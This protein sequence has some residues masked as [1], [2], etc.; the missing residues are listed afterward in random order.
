[1]KPI[2]VILFFSIFIDTFA[3]DLHIETASTNVSY[4]YFSLPNESE[5]N[6]VDL[7]KKDSNISYRLFYEKNYGRW[8]WT[9]LYAPLSIND[10]FTSEKGF[11]FNN[12]NFTAG[13]MTSVK[14]VFNSYRLGYR[15]NYYYGGSR[16]YYGALI[17]IRDAEICITQNTSK[18]CYDNIGPVPLLNVGVELNFKNIY[19]ASN[20]DGLWSSRGSAYDANLE[21]GLNLRL[22]KLAT[23]IRV[24]GGGADNETLVNFAQFQSAYLKLIF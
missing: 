10:T 8:S 1:M 24:L 4:N 19:L 7:P 20:I 13:Q 15:R 17:K 6:R 23:G 3:S 2:L 14:Y 9:L 11:K 18:D 22:F 12:T 16:L 21:L 5:A